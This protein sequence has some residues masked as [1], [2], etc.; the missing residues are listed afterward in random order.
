MKSPIH[1]RHYQQQRPSGPVKTATGF[2]WS[3]SNITRTKA[4]VVLSV[5]VCLVT[6]VC[7]NAFS[8]KDPYS[9]MA[10]SAAHSEATLALAKKESQEHMHGMQ[11]LYDD[12]RKKPLIIKAY[13]LDDANAPADAMVVHFV[14]HG[15]G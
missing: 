11:E 8:A 3:G 1:S 10:A 9:E 14:R 6:T 2:I 13:A 7:T 5:I 4:A 12:M 15:Q